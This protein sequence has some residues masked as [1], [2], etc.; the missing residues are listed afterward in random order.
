MVALERIYTLFGWGSCKF[1]DFFQLVQC[2]IA[3]EKWLPYHKFSYDA[4]NTPNV[5]GFSIIFGAQ[6]HLRRAIPTCRNFFGKD[7]LL[8][9]LSSQGSSKSKVA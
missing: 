8:L 1:Y 6:E 7:Q 2:G 4:A 9:L 5:R 3:R